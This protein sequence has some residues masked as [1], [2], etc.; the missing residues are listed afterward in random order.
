RQHAPHEAGSQR[1]L[2]RPGVVR[3]RTGSCQGHTGR[4]SG[5]RARVRRGVKKSLGRRG[6]LA[7]D[8]AVIP[9][10][11]STVLTGAAS[12]LGRAF[13]LELAARRA[14]VFLT[15]IDEAGLAETA[16][17]AERLGA[18]VR[19]ARGD[20]ARR[21]DWERI[22]G[23]ATGWLGPVD[24]LINNAGVAVGGPIG[25]IPLEDWEWITR[26][27]QWGP[28]Y[29]CHYFLPAMRQRGRGHV[30]NVASIAAFACAGDMG[31]Y[32]VTKAAVVA[33]TETLAGELAGTGVGAT[34]LC[35]F[36]FTT[37]IAKNARSSSSTVTPTGLEKIMKRTPVQA[38]DV[39]RLALEACA[40]DRLYVFPHNEAK[41]IA[42]FK[43]LVPEIFLRR[44]GPFAAKSARRVRL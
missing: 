4:S 44:M 35:P 8:A 13:A 22:H 43:R 11:P 37:N 7:D 24:L 1:P 26:I 5:G 16:R 15:D 17:E 23:E 28:I 21:E 9:S 36:F 32:N 41:G 31:P 33:L 30:L 2:H 40:R 34:V 27:N 18:T 42:A 20:V 19:T 38:A 10:A 14:R 6:A 12:G 25:E 39:A 29:G 3:P